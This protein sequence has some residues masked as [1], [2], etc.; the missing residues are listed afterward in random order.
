[1]AESKASEYTTTSI[2][3]ITRVT[4]LTML[5]KGEGCISSHQGNMMEVGKTTRNMVKAD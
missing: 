5:K 3:S 4:G 1:M 2:I